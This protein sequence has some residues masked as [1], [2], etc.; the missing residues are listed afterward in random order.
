VRKRAE[1]IEKLGAKVLV[2]TLSQPSV[3]KMYQDAKSFPFQF[4]ADPEKKLYFQFGLERVSIWRMFRPKVLW[5][6]LSLIFRGWLVRPIKKGEDV[7]QLGGDFII[8]SERKLVYGYRCVD[9]SDRPSA[10]KLIQ[11]LQKL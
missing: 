1:E 10:K 7:L 9:P 8:N 6:Y 5:H 2:V 4:V 3:L 11:E